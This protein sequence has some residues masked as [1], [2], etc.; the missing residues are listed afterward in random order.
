VKSA[1]SRRTGAA[2]LRLSIRIRLAQFNASG[3]TATKQANMTSARGLCLFISLG[4]LAQMGTAPEPLQVVVASWNVGC[5]QPPPESLAV[6]LETACGAD[7]YAVALQEVVDLNSPISYCS[8]HGAGG[9]SKE[10]AAWEERISAELSSHERMACRQLGGMV[11]LVYVSTA[12]APFVS[13]DV[14]AAG[15]GPLGFGNKGAIAATLLLKGSSLTFLCCHLAAG[16]KGP[17][18]RN[19]EHHALVSRLRLGVQGAAG[20][21]P[22]DGA[23]GRQLLFWCG[24]LN[25]RLALGNEE[26][27]ALAV[28][29]DFAALL[30]ADEL[31][32]CRAAGDAFA[33]F[34]EAAIRFPPT[35]KYDLHSDGFDSSAKQ[36]APAY[37]DRVLWRAEPNVACEGYTSH[38]HLRSSDHRAISARMR[39]ELLPFEPS[40]QPAFRA[41]RPV[42]EAL[43]GAI[44]RCA[45]PRPNRL[46]GAARATAVGRPLPCYAP[47]PAFHLYQHPLR[48]CV[49]C[50]EPSASAYELIGSV[51][52]SV[53]DSL[54]AKYGD[55][56]LTS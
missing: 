6:W 42:L 47:A 33:G 22:P 26:A 5:T 30:A 31:S 32:S 38:P 2:L 20:G 55:P 46:P 39:V 37:C 4:K 35:Y 23:A 52:P 56:G 11:L 40:L 54:A 13:A 14:Q 51:P 28:A 45:R 29:G 49:P 36:R 8:C 12:L 44:R 18:K 53:R 15:T 7:V 25:Y 43:D 48:R 27:R 9:L 10:A 3:K 19:A 50:L 1:G 41:S 34:S 17:H 24:D 21:A 16:K